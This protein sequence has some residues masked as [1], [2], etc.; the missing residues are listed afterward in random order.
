MKGRDLR[1]GSDFSVH[2]DEKP[3]ITWYPTLNSDA[4]EVLTG[5]WFDGRDPSEADGT[6]QAQAGGSGAEEDA[7]AASAGGYAS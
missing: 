3:G 4:N 6:Y 7:S 5:N 2:T 1:V